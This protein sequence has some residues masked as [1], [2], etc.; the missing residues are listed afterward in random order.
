MQEQAKIIYLTHRLYL[1]LKQVSENGSKVETNHSDQEVNETLCHLEEVNCMLRKEL[2]QAEERVRMIETGNQKLLEDIKK[3][4]NYHEERMQKLEIEFQ[5][6]IQELQRIHEEEMKHLH[7][8][9]SK[10]CFSKE[11]LNKMIGKSASS[12]SPNGAESNMEELD[13][14]ERFSALEDMHKKLIG[15]LQQQHQ[16]EVAKL[17]KEKDQLL[18][19][20]TAATMAAIVAMRRA[21][22]EELEKTRCTTNIRENADMSEL[23]IEYEKELQTLNKDLEMLSVQH[24]EKC[25]ENSQLSQELQH[26]RK[27]LRQY[28]RENQELKMKQRQANDISPFHSLNGKHFTPEGTDTY[29]MEIILRAREAEMQF[30]RQEA[31]SL[32]EELKLARLDTI[33]AQNKLESLCMGTPDEKLLEDL[34]WATWS[35]DRQG[36]SQMF[37]EEAGTNQCD[38]TVQD[39]TVISQPFRAVRSKSLKEGLSVQ[40]QM[41]LFKS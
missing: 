30:L 28:Q 33:Y 34:K 23:H 39:K 17:L 19:E 25:L 4:E 13:K 9:Y 2:E 31:Q 14:Y 20:E 32:K 3:I 8:Y 35:S 27:T 21:H 11:K 24:T 36:Q 1:D 12:Q 40:E 5:H 18:K 6:K 26:E 15:D 16:K 38:A 29:E 37:S 10:S 7:D 41:S 22:K